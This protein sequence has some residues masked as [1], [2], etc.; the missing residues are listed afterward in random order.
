MEKVCPSSIFALR[1]ALHVVAG[2]VHS[3]GQIC[4]TGEYT[5]HK[6]TCCGPGKYAQGHITL[7]I[8]N[9]GGKNLPL[10]FLNIFRNKSK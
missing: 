8:S 9:G 4:P 10:F 3:Q 5:H 2:Q 7:I 6:M 1:V